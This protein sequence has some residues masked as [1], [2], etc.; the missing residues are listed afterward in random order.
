MRR[1]LVRANKTQ[2]LC[3]PI[4]SPAG[5]FSTSTL[6]KRSRL[7]VIDRMQLGN[8]P[9]FPFGHTQRGSGSEV[10]VSHWEDGRVFD[11]Q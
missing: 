3:P 8:V 5:V 4:H 10:M 1:R 2:K 6:F 7:S 9:G 11:G